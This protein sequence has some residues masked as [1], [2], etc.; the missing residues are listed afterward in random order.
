MQIQQDVLTKIAIANDQLKM[1]K[2]KL[3]ELLQACGKLLNDQRY[4]RETLAIENLINV[5][6]ENN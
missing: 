1:P 2:G 4:L 5:M 6:S 3:L